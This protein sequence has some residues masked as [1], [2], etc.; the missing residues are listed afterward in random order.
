L[1]VEQGHDS[2]VV[3]LVEQGHDSLVVLLVEQGH[4]SQCNSLVIYTKGL[5]D[6]YM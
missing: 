4:D 3:L 6:Y 2:L 5:F 1:L